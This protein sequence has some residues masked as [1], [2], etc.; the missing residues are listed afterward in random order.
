MSSRVGDND[1]TRKMV[2]RDQNSQ[3]FGPSRQCYNTLFGGNLDFPKINQIEKS[4]V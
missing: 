1:S 4:L 3:S 2:N